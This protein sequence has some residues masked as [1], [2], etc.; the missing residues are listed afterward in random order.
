VKQAMQA[1]VVPVVELE[2]VSVAS[3][4][5]W[6]SEMGYV[7]SGNHGYNWFCLDAQSVKGNAHI[8]IRGKN[9][10]ILTLLNTICR[11]A[12]LVW[13]I[14]PSSIVIMPRSKALNVPQ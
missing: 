6:W 11:Q 14:E 13:W 4:L 9:M 1:A 12:D 8:T 2:K 3:A 5:G 7:H 10:S